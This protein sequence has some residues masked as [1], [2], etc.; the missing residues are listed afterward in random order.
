M[1]GCSAQ[2]RSRSS[3]AAAASAVR[4]KRKEGFTMIKISPSILSADFAN[5]QRDIERIA[6]AD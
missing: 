3:Y 1:T 5:L 4:N 2:R 6:S